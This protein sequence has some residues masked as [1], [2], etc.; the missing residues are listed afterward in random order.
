MVQLVTDTS[1]KPLIWKPSACTGKFRYRTVGHKS[2]PKGGR[3]TEGVASAS[4]QSW[5]LEDLRLP[6]REA[7]R[8]HRK[9]RQSDPPAPSLGLSTCKLEMVTPPGL[10]CLTG[11]CKRTGKR[12]GRQVALLNSQSA[13]L[14][15]GTLLAW[16]DKL[17]WT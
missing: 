12:L 11:Q 7:R 16:E 2:S 4:S 5:N 3:G 13:V 17:Y 15:P 6:R 14:R 1:D 10:M 9:S 8:G